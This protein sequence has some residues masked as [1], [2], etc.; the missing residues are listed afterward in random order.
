LYRY[1]PSNNQIEPLAPGRSSL[2]IIAVG[3]R[4]A[5]ARE[6]VDGANEALYLVPVSPLDESLV[7]HPIPLVRGP[8]FSR[9][10]L[11]PGDERVLATSG[12]GKNANTLVFDV[13]DGDLIDRFKGAAISGLYPEVELPGLSAVSPD[14][15]FAVYRTPNG[16]LALRDLEVSSSCL[17][18][19]AGASDHEVAGFSA[20]GLIYLESTPQRLGYSEVLAHDLRVQRST[21]LGDGIRS[22]HLAAIPG[23]AHEIGDETL[24]WAISVSEGSYWA[25]QNNGAEALGLDDVMFLPRDSL[26][27]WVLDSDYDRQEGVRHM[28]V[29]LVEPRDAET[30]DPLDAALDLAPQDTDF[31]Q[32]VP[33]NREICLSSGTPGSW[34]H[35]CGFADDKRFLGGPS[36]P[37]SEDPYKPQPDEND[38]P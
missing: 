10:V 34:A 17:V 20:D 25:V 3:E 22:H 30:V 35:G 38:S 29:S 6:L 11:T 32:Q 33:G 16:A 14:G 7:G 15:S 21:V 1:D 13:P 9:V 23:R 27:A 2:R 8:A 19:G 18:R 24:P 5:V 26:A 4:H 28:A 12:E 31:V 36:L 37:D